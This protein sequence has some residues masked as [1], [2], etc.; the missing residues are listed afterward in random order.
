MKSQELF[1]D[2]DNTSFYS[3]D[4]KKRMYTNIVKI[5]EPEVYEFLMH[6]Y[7]ANWLVA[8]EKIEKEYVYMKSMKEIS[9]Y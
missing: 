2:S 9:R 4:N 5:D 6:I 8:K 7:C 1:W 3:V